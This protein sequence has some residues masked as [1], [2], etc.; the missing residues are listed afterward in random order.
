MSTLLNVESSGLTEEFEE[1]YFEEPAEG[2]SVRIT[3]KGTTANSKNMIREVSWHLK[4]SIITL[5]AV[6][7]TSLHIFSI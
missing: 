7:I 2:S 3:L 6:S 1:F 4:Q 5:A